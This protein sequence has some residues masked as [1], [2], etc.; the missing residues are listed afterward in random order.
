MKRLVTIAT[1]AGALLLAMTGTVV[2]KGDAQG[3][4]K[5]TCIFFTDPVDGAHTWHC[6]PP[7]VEANLG[8]PPGPSLNFVGGIDPQNPPPDGSVRIGPPPGAE[9]VGT[10]N[11][12]RADLY[13]G[14]PC[15]QGTSGFVALPFGEYHWCH[16]YSP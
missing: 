6:I 8:G 16:H 3:A 11:L 15:P 14:Q 7:G 10:E 9:F 4:Q 12:I 5:W 1:L 2:A 13:A